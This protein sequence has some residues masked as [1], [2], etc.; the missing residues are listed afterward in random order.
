MGWARETCCEISSICAD[1]RRRLCTQPLHTAN[2]L[3]A[4]RR[5]CKKG[6]QKRPRMKNPKTLIEIDYHQLCLGTR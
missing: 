3:K 2:G 4:V 6:R 5:I 1:T